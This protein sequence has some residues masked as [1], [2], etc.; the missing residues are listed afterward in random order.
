MFPFGFFVS[1]FRRSAR[2]S[3]LRAT[4]GA[5]RAFFVG[6]GFHRRHGPMGCV[7]RKGH[8][9]SRDLCPVFSDGHL[10]PARCRFIP[11]ARLI[12]SSRAEFG[13]SGGDIAHFSRSWPGSGSSILHLGVLFALGE[14]PPALRVA[15]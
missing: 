11:V 5:S 6:L 4:G 7:S 8:V 13:F 1:F 2:S 10:H 3:G 12:F 14:L 9:E 15:G